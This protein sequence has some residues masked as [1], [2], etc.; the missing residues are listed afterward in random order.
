MPT[1]M[2]FR[3]KKKKCDKCRNSSSWSNY[4]VFCNIKNKH[5]RNNKTACDSFK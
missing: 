2:R 1:Y 4:K 5:V 3:V